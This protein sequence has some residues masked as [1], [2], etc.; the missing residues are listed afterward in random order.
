MSLPLLDIGL[1]TPK[2]L[3]HKKKAEDGTVPLLG[4]RRCHTGILQSEWIIAFL[5]NHRSRSSSIGLPEDVCRG[6][7]LEPR[8]CPSRVTTVDVETRRVDKAE[9]T[10]SAR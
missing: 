8:G 6:H 7:D 2:L 9:E 1:C 4:A 5:G 10:W 3:L